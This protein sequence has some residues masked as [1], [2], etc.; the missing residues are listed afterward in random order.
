MSSN[1][2][3]HADWSVQHQNQADYETYNTAFDM[4]LGNDGETNP[5]QPAVEVMVWMNHVHQG[6]LGSYVETVNL[7]GSTYDLYAYWGGSPAWKVFS[8]IQKNGTWS[9]NNIDVFSF[10]NYL[11]HNKQWISGNQYIIGIE[12]GN[13]IIQGKGTF[14][15]TYSLRVN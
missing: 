15:H 3:I 13:E 2:S 12:A 9:Y 7:A 4:W 1:P 11:W 5:S 8:F 6:P 14:T 10:F